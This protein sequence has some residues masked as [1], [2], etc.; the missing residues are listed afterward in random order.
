MSEQYLY[1]TRCMSLSL[2]EISLGS[3]ILLLLAMVND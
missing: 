3:Q 1:S 2:E